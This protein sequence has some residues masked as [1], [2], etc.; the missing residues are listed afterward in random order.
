M[1]LPK[2]DHLEYAV[3]L[4]F[5]T[6]NNETEYKALIKGLDLAK[7]LGVKLVVIQGNSQLIIGQVNGTCEAKEE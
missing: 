4:Q 7:A 1:Q 6:T 2:G 5:H 3:H